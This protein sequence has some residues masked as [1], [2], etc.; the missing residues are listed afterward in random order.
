MCFVTYWDNHGQHKPPYSFVHCHAGILHRNDTLH[1]QTSQTSFLF[2]TLPR[3]H[4]ATHWYRQWYCICFATQA[5]CHTLSMH[6]PLFHVVNCEAYGSVTLPYSH[7]ALQSNV[8]VAVTRCLGELQA[9][10]NTVHYAH[11]QTRLLFH[12]LSR[13]HSVLFLMLNNYQLSHIRLSTIQ[14]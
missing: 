5:V 12:T 9:S 10:P 11:A 4:S 8:P 14:R 13:R 6:Q 7:D 1:M 3:R 2:H